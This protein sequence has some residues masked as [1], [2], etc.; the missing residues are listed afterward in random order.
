MKTKINLLLVVIITTAISFQS[1]KKDIQANA[2]NK[3]LTQAEKFAMGSSSVLHT[4]DGTT[5]TLILRP[6][7]DDG[8]DVVGVFDASNP[9]EANINNKH[10]KEVV[11][12][13][14]THFGLT[15][16]VR[17]FIEFDGLSLIPENA[18]ISKATCYLY[19][20]TSSEAAPQ[21]NSYYPGSP[22]FSYGPNG[23]SVERVLSS[24]D[25]NT[26]TWNNQPAVTKQNSST[27]TPL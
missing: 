19:G 3:N 13:G 23:C 22:Y 12:Y 8:K 27:I 7:P 25:E 21:G 4:T 9:D 18:I 1:C 20:L 15:Y 17:A 6:G 5:Q 24:W 14:W 2:M 26:L 10:I 11:C 16:N